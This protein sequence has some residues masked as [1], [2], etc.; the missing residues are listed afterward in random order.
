MVVARAADWD[1]GRVDAGDVGS[2]KAAL[3]RTVLAGRS[4]LSPVDRASAGAALTSLLLDLPETASARSVAAYHSFGTEP[5]T[6]AALQSLAARGARVL[7]PVVRADRDLD[8]AIYD[9]AQQPPQDQR[10]MWSPTGERQGLGAVAT[11]DLVV[12]P[13]LSVATDGTRLGRG[14]GSYDRALAR[15]PAGVPV[16]ALLY[17]GE[18]V[19]ALPAEPHDRPVDVVVTPA[20]VHRVPGSP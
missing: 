11:V 18:L 14:G 19:D 7:L 6:S 16:V 2:I 5:S 4:R 8:W 10:R 20:G 12:V 1:A 13:A 3:R 17:A 15:V 9:P